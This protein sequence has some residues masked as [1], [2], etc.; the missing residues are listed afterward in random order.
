MGRRRAGGAAKT[1]DETAVGWPPPGR[2]TP[3]AVEIRHTAGE[4]GGG[5]VGGSSRAIAG[6]P[7]ESGP[8]GSG[9]AAV[10]AGAV[11]LARLP[12]PSVAQVS[13]RAKSLTPVAQGRSASRVF[14]PPSAVAL[15]RAD[16]GHFDSPP[17]APLPRLHPASLCTLGKGLSDNS[18]VRVVLGVVESVG[19]APAPL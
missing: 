17:P 14:L 19:P 3:A 1:V 2:G 10:G 8:G 7:A 5:V 18:L 15:H 16:L 13:G 9:P 12:F 6:N 4:L 11:R